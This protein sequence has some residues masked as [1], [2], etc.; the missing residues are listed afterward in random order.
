M[1]LI[2]A[3]K[4]TLGFH[5]SPPLIGGFH[6]RSQQETLET[7][8]AAS[9]WLGPREDLETDEAFLQIIPYTILV[10]EGKVIHYTRSKKS[11]ETRLRGQASL[12]FGGHIEHADVLV[13]D[14]TIDLR[15]TLVYSSVREIRE[16]LKGPHTLNTCRWAGF[17]FDDTTPVG[18][19]H[20]GVVGVWELTHFDINKAQGADG[21]EDLWLA[22]PEE[23]QKWPSW[24]RFETWSRHLIQ[25]LPSLMP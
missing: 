4:R 24:S 21:V 22:S 8:M 5:S 15:T 3:A 19:V 6:A 7:L 25:H 14:G 11:G 10:S 23:I 18:R 20:L 16:E 13:K 9:L 12:G 1:T 2:L 17:V